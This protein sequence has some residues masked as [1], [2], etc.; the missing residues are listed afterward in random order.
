MMAP[1]V[2]SWC[3]GASW[4]RS[5]WPHSSTLLGLFLLGG[6]SSLKK[7]CW[8][9]KPGQGNRPRPISRNSRCVV[10]QSRCGGSSGALGSSP[11]CR[12]F[13]MPLGPARAVSACAAFLLAPEEGRVGA[14]PQTPPLS[15]G[16]LELPRSG[17][18]TS[19]PSVVCGLQFS[20]T[21]DLGK[22][23]GRFSQLA[24]GSGCWHVGRDPGRWGPRESLFSREHGRES[25]ASA[26]L[27]AGGQHRELKAWEH[28][29]LR[30][31]SRRPRGGGGSREGQQA[32]WE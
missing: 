12:G 24:R 20:E 29:R 18:M 26:N 31:V 4:P 1:V 27:R 22:G 10:A 6:G 30:S 11:F 2:W 5:E 19:G 25:R 7:P 3:L 17:V 32:L 16:S 28:L 8:P 23:L 21:L 13:R 14:L 15:P 9:C